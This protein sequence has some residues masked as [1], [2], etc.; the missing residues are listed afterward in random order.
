MLRNTPWTTPRC[1]PSDG[2][3]AATLSQPYRGYIVPGSTLSQLH[4]VA[5]HWNTPDGSNW[6]YRAMQYRHNTT[7]RL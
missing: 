2:Y 1:S 4:L 6:P 3:T 7:A 5:S